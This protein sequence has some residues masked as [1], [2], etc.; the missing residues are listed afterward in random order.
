MTEE[1]LSISEVML[2]K[3][4]IKLLVSK[5]MIKGE[6][7]NAGADYWTSKL[8]A[9]HHEVRRKLLRLMR[10]HMAK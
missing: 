5:D 8:T 7:E 2:L 4:M 9:D 6:I 10:K 3:Q 1:K